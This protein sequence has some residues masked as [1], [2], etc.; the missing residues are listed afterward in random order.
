MRTL[1]YNL[2]AH[3]APEVRFFIEQGGATLLAVLSRVDLQGVR[4][5]SM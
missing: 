1:S 3:K 4:V 5:D 2:A